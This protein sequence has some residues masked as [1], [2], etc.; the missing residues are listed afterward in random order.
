MLSPTCQFD[1]KYYPSQTQW[2]VSYSRFV[3]I[4]AAIH[5]ESGT[6][7]EGDKCD[8]L[9]NA[10]KHLNKAEMH[11]FVP[12]KEMSFEEGGVVLQA[13]Q[14]TILSVN[15][16]TASQFCIGLIFSYLLMH[17]VDKILSIALM[18]IREKCTKH[19]NFCQSLESSSNTKNIHE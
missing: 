6:S 5:P 7:K 16:T 2:Y 10:I 11:T 14:I 13:N 9:R 18:I 19:F 15:I 8:E 4:P 1:L 17:P 3:Q 12:G